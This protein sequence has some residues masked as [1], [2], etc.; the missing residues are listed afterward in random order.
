M[1]KEKNPFI[2]VRL[3]SG[4]L[5]YMISNLDT[6][7]DIAQYS[8]IGMILIFFSL[9]S[10]R[11]LWILSTEGFTGGESALFTFEKSASDSFC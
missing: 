11:S 2:L 1:M 7:A 5:K 9:S 6:K 3:K 4:Q 10:M 8:I